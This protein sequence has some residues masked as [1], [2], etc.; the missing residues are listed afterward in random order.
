MVA[1]AGGAAGCAAAAAPGCL[2]RVNASLTRPS[3]LCAPV[4]ARAVLGAQTHKSPPLQHRGHGGPRRLNARAPAHNLRLSIASTTCPRSASSSRNTTHD[5]LRTSRDIVLVLRS[6]HSLRWLIHTCC[7]HRR[8]TVINLFFALLHLLHRY[9]T[10]LTAMVRAWI[11]NEEDTGR[12]PQL[13]SISLALLIVD[14]LTSPPLPPS[15]PPLCAPPC[16]RPARAALHHTGVVGVHPAPA[17]AWR[18]VLASA[19]HP[20]RRHRPP[21]RRPAGRHPRS[22]LLQEPRRHQG[23]PADAARLPHQDQGLLLR[24]PARGR[25]DPLRPRRHGVLRRPPRPRRQVDPH[26]SQR[27]GHDRPAGRHVPPLHQRR[28]RLRARHAP[29][30]GQPQ[31]VSAQRTSSSP[32]SS[33]LPTTR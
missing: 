12:L 24:A 18:I 26:R 2:S 5:R 30:Q 33:H 3:D 11:Y 10:R 28:A 15:L 31:V 29:L 17:D 23:D 32:A 14:A 9:R 20:E 1:C 19:H 6:E 22:A 13:P 4:I 16:S 25:G 8:L 7:P 21:Q 27:R